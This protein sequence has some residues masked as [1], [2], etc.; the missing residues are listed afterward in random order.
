MAGSLKNEFLT[1]IG[2]K[3]ESL[4]SCQLGLEKVAA[5]KS[6]TCGQIQM[7]SAQ[8][9]GNQLSYFDWLKQEYGGGMERAGERSSSCIALAG[10]KGASMR[11]DVNLN[12][13]FS[14]PGTAISNHF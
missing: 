5:E 7:R 2:W 10:T 12:E 6:Q 3:H 9:N 14:M 11:P 1:Q 8:G 13:H 4:P